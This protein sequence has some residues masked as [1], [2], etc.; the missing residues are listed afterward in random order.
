MNSEK[1]PAGTDRENSEPDVKGVETDV[2]NWAPLSV[3]NAR[4]MR[5]DYWP[6]IWMTFASMIILFVTLAILAYRMG[7]QSCH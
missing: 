1:N 7:A 2:E 3:R 6:S 4:R 5:K